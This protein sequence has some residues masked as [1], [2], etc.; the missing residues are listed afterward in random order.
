MVKAYLHLEPGD[1]RRRG[2]LGEFRSVEPSEGAGNCYNP[3]GGGCL[4]IQVHIPPPPYKTG[5]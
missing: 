4:G 5:K 2:I 3:L 1:G